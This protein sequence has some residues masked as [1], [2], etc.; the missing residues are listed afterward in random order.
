MRTVAQRGVLRPEAGDLLLREPNGNDLQRRRNSETAHAVIGAS[1]MMDSSRPCAI[2]RAAS[3]MLGYGTTR[4]YFRFVWAQLSA[5][6]PMRTPTFAPAFR[7]ASRVA[8]LTPPYATR[9]PAAPN[10]CTDC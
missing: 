9:P 2:S 1:L 3:S 10:A 5:V 8:Y 7:R 4:P 6:D